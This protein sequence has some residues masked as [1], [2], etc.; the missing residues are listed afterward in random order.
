[1]A[2]EPRKEDGATDGPPD[3][4]EVSTLTGIDTEKLQNQ[5]ADILASG[6]LAPP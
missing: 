4:S 3:W 6:N 2:T 1:M 5:Y